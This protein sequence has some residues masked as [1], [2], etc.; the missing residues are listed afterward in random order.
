MGTTNTTKHPP[1]SV[2]SVKLLITAASVAATLGGWVAF[3]IPAPTNQDATAQPIEVNTNLAPIPTILPKP[4]DQGGAIRISNQPTNQQPI[5]LTLRSVN[6][7]PPSPVTVT[8]S[9]R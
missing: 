1:R 4:S 9:S 3:S 5:I 7:Q 6:P 8:R 2:P